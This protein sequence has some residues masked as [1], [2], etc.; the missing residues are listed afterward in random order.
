MIY[1]KEFS[2]PPVDRREVLRYAGVQ[3]AT[4][5]V[6]ALLDRV[7]EESKAL[8]KYK[9]CYGIFD[10]SEKEGELDF[11]FCKTRSRSLV[12]RLSECESCVVFCA[13]VGADID[14]LIAKYLVISPSMAVLAQALGSERVEALCE[15]FC[16]FIAREGLGKY[17]CTV[18]FSPGYGDLP[19]E[20]QKDI[21]AI[22]DPARH[23]GVSLGDDMF[24]T[25]MKSVTAIFGIKK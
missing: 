5:E 7:I 8:L 19:L 11:G 2:A 12:K 4:A 3:S 22:L 17:S 23:V 24:M 13:T 6:D 25:P 15:E 21:F 16:S 10:I 9:C 20:M 1:I 14:R 18:R